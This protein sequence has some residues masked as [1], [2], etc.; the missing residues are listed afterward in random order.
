MPSP[1]DG[2]TINLGFYRHS[3]PYRQTV[4]ASLRF[5]ADLSNP[6]ASEFVLPSGQS[7]HPLSPHY[8]DQTA[9][10]AQ[11]ERIRIG[12]ADAVAPVTRLELKPG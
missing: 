3:N 6:A 12:S 2:T 7:G 8:R 10:W 4:G 9:L 5:T 11:G 1:G